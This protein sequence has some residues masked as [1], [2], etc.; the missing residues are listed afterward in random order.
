MDQRLPGNIV[1]T[2]WFRGCLLAFDVT[3]NLPRQSFLI[4]QVPKEFDVADS[5]AKERKFHLY[6]GFCQR[7]GIFFLPFA[8][9]VFHD[10]LKN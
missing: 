6:N 1:L 9:E 5:L 8:V 2:N 10:L 4:T 7:I 3:V